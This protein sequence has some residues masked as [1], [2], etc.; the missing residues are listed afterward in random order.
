MAAS[1]CA[2]PSARDAT[3]AGAAAPRDAALYV[4]VNGIPA[5]E[6]AVLVVPPSGF[7]VD[8]RFPDPAAV[9]P[10]TLSL[11]GFVWADNEVVRFGSPVHRHARGAVYRVERS[12]ALE[13]G[14]LTL[15]ATVELADGSSESA[16]FSL[17]V[18]RPSQPAPLATPQWIQLNVDA[19]RDGDGRRDL[20]DDLAVF[21]LASGRASLAE[22]AA[23]AWVIDE[24][25]SRTQALYDAPDPSGLP[26]AEL[27]AVTFSETPPEAGP[28]TEI[29]VAGASP[30]GAGVTG[31]IGNVRL[32]P[33]NR[34][35]S[36]VACDDRLPSGVFPREIR[37]Y[38]DEPEYQAAFG[39]LV[40]VPIGRDPQDEVV[41]GPT[42]DPRDPAQAARMRTIRRGIETF[43]Q[44]VASIAAHEAGHAMGLV[45]RGPPAAGLFGGSQGAEF[46]HAL[47]PAGV[48]SDENLLMKPGPSFR[49]GDLTGQGVAGLPRLRAIEVAYLQG[50]ILLDPRIDGIHRPPTALGVSP[51]RVD[52]SGTPLQQIEV[53]GWD[54]RETPTLRVRG[55]VE[56]RLTQVTLTRGEN[57]A[58][59]Q[60]SSWVLA[61]A[62]LPGVY[63]VEIE[64]PDGQQSTLAAALQVR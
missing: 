59:D 2:L 57:G 58:P 53:I 31:V 21:G 40:S 20:P 33:G 52:P 16:F 55:P 4:G 38:E 13:P 47:S 29:C 34:N 54:L 49:F 56:F 15:G 5:D 9:L 1:E 41:L 60:I 32:D 11:H 62:L 46:T 25:V 63:D 10:D 28:Y 61:P 30:V 26:D 8:V 64:N 48:V 45:P 22:R 12:D 36:D 42:Y 18:R 51:R 7:L 19:D 35:P 17:A 44:A 43:A 14:S 37:D 27:L 24:I 50:R 3:P 6:S 39:P 23:E